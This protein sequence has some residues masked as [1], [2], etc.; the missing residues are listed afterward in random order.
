MATDFA[1]RLLAW[2]DK[3]GRKNLPW[4]R[5]RSTYRVWV[6]EIMLQQTQVQTVIPYFE[7]F[8]QS[9][10]DVTSLADARLD[11][12]LHLWSGLG[13]YAR[14]RNLHSAAEII[15]DKHGGE[16]P[17]TFEAV[18]ALPGIGRS[19]AGAILSLA[20]GQRHPILDG[21]AKRVLA[22][23]AAIEA[24]PGKTSVSR[25]LWDLA[26]ESTPAAR[27]DAYTQAIMDLGA[28][29]CTRTSPVCGSC[30]VHADCKALSLGDVEQYPGRKPKKDKPLRQTTMVLAVANGAV[31]LERRPASGIWGG[32]WS[33]P[34]VSD[35]D[36]WCSRRFA[37]SAVDIESWGNL[38]HSFSHYDLDISPV[39]VRVATVSSKVADE[40]DSTWYQFEESPPGGIAAPV[41]KLIDTLK[42]STRVTNH[43]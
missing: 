10:P 21:N 3:H 42:N 36:E 27:V 17:E 11:D 32:L 4:Q 13:Y 7:R 24:W 31:Y 18:V 43:G 12:V 6:S 15:C 37:A 20:L 23:H 34:E 19:T 2:Y 29:L 41:M 9:F 26:E 40:G 5:D 38:R 16:I 22:R 1:S 33:L 8:M 39:V 35:V 30:P 14:A 28:T 25:R